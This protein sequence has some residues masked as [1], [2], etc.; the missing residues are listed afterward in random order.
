[1]QWSRKQLS[2]QDKLAMRSENVKMHIGK[3]AMHALP[4]IVHSTFC[5]KERVATNVSQKPR[6]PLVRV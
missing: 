3:S 2:Y 1:M 4:L 5:L 6:S